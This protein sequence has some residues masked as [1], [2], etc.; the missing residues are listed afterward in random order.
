MLSPPLHRCSSCT[1]PSEPFF[2][3][4][5][6]AQQVSLAL[7]SGKGLHSFVM[8]DGEI[9]RLLQVH[10]PVRLM[11]REVV[12]LAPDDVRPQQQGLLDH[13][14]HQGFLEHDLL[15]LLVRCHEEIASGR[16]LPRPVGKDLYILQRLRLCPLPCRHGSPSHLL[17]IELVQEVHNIQNELKSLLRQSSPLLPRQ[18]HPTQPREDASMRDS[19]VLVR[20]GEL[21]QSK[22]VVGG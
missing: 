4:S 9:K 7:R 22:H 6:P 2:S 13:P 21:H 14:A 18:A 16:D 10:Q 17:P 8:R 11:E 5:S 12:P 3:S 20:A 15:L 19:G 1:Y